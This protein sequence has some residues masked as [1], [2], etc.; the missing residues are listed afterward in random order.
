MAGK[1]LAS[2]LV[3]VPLILYP[4]AVSPREAGAAGVTHAGPDPARGLGVPARQAGWAWECGQIL[5][6]TLRCPACGRSYR[7][8]D[9]GLVEER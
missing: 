4:P 6:K 7:E 8:E 3:A 9:T 2:L 5:D 1:R